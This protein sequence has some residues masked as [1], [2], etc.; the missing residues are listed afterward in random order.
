MPWVL[1]TV[2]CAHRRCANSWLRD[3]RVWWQCAHVGAGPGIRRAGPRCR[4]RDG[5][6]AGGAVWVG[7]SAGGA[8][9]VGV[10]G[11]DAVGVGAS[12][13]GAV[14]FVASA[15]GVAGVGVDLGVR[16]RHRRCTRRALTVRIRRLRPLCLSACQLAA[17]RGLRLHQAWCSHAWG[18]G[19]AGST[20]ARLRR[21]RLRLPCW[22]LRRGWRSRRG[23]RRW[24]C[25]RW[26]R[27]CRRC[28]HRC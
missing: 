1:V 10:D 2:P 16:M 27:S 13:G 8:A 7:A 23:R 21:R 20:G 25:W 12:A 4:T 24:R 14:G 15:G 28:P 5:A 18:S 6:S 3:G 26:R 11:G 19:G 17:S 9:G 22:R